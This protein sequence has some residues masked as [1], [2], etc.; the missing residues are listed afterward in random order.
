MCT[1]T[2]KHF[3]AHL[4]FNVYIY[5]PRVL[6]SFFT[7]KRLLSKAVWETLSQMHTIKN[8]QRHNKNSIPVLLKLV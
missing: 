7:A 3:K 6:L 5:L 4:I 2:A 8:Q 1:E